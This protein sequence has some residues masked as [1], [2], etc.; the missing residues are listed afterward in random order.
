ML[1]LSSQS[2]LFHAH[3]T[4]FVYSVT[5]PYRRSVLKAQSLTLA[6][7][8]LAL[9]MMITSPTFRPHR[10]YNRQNAICQ[11]SFISLHV[12]HLT[13]VSDTA[14]TPGWPRDSSGYTAKSDKFTAHT[15]PIWLMSC[16]WHVLEIMPSGIII[17]LCIIYTTI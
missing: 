9:L 1:K 10:L 12:T 16:H 8:T 5:L 4:N 17:L 2:K 15:T 3:Y 6:N 11:F 13:H 14:H 7:T